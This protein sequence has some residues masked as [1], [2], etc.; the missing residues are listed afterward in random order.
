MIGHG[1]H[2]LVGALCVVASLRALDLIGVEMT[3]TSAKDIYN[4]LEY[5][6]SLEELDLSQSGI[7]DDMVISWESALMVN[8]NLKILTLRGNGLTG[9]GVQHLSLVLLENTHLK[10]L[11]LSYNECDDTGAQSL[12][13]A[14]QVN[15]VLCRLD[16]SSNEQIS[17]NGW[18]QFVA[19][20]ENNRSLRSL[21]VDFNP[22]ITEQISQSMQQWMARNQPQQWVRPQIASHLK[23]S[24]LI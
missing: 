1:L 6:P 9:L 14:L 22:S 15:T 16:L 11:D 5:H 4:L 23:S 21:S 20:A 8:E 13:I 2:S 17:F 18:A 10:D 12:G 7:T 24:F 3:A 19:E